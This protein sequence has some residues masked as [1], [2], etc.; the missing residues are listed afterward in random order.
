MHPPKVSLLVPNYNYAR[1][2][3]ETFASIR[4]Q[5]FQDYEVVISDNCSTDDSVS[6][7]REFM[8]QDPRVRFQAQPSNLGMVANWNWCLQNARGEYV[9]YL[10]ADDTMC[11]PE[12]LGKMVALIERHPQA[13]L[14][15]S[16]RNIINS[17]S[18][19]T[20]VW[21]DLIHPGLIPGKKLIAKCLLRD[22]NLIGEPSVVMFRRHAAAR[23]FNPAYN[24]LS[25]LEMWFHLLESG[26][27]VYTP[28]P[29]NAFRIHDLQQTKANAA[30]QAGQ[31]EMIRLFTE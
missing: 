2:L 24:Q 30:T 10:L 22:A 17:C 13:V 1:Y 14:V 28:E 23:G 3:P 4:A 27:A 16:A 18:Q 8:G 12:C 21:N 6:I 19:T 11:S 29:L 15:A 9:K 7:I 25:D 31:R 26:D 5:D 20:A